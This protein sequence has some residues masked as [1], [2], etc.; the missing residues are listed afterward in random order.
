MRKSFSYSMKSFDFPLN[1]GEVYRTIWYPVAGVVA[2]YPK[3]TA[4]PPSPM[5]LL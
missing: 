5:A 2:P 3:P 1:G 4:A